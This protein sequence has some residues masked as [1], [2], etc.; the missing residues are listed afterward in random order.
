MIL[1]LWHHIKIFFYC[2]TKRQFN[3]S[4]CVSMFSQYMHIREFCIWMH[5]HMIKLRNSDLLKISVQHLKPIKVKFSKMLE[6]W[7]Y[8]EKKKKKEK[9]RKMANPLKNPLMSIQV[10]VFK[11]CI[12]CIQSI[13]YAYISLTYRYLYRYQSY[14]EYGAYLYEIT[15]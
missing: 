4:I 12:R 10:I 11:T 5:M 13:T 2:P 6:K 9:E 7:F 14:I 1:C 3:E 15:L 8:R